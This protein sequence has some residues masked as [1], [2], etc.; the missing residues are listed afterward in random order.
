MSDA[1]I[2]AV[3]VAPVETSKGVQYRVMRSFYGSTVQLGDFA[4]ESDAFRAAQ[5][6]K[7]RMEESWGQLVEI[8][9]L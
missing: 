4:K 3:T 1:R 9:R 7:Q 5:D 2:I 6:F 8:K